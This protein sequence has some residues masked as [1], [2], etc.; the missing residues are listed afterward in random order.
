M[1]RERGE[2]GG[3]GLAEGGW[4]EGGGVT[5]ATPCHLCYTSKVVNILMSELGLH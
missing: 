1:Q 4:G 3:L 5:K 2:G